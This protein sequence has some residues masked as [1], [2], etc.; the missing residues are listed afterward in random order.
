[1]GRKM[2]HRP[3]CTY[4]GPKPAFQE[5]GQESVHQLHIYGVEEPTFVFR[6]MPEVSLSSHVVTT[7]A[8][9]TGTLHC[10]PIPVLDSFP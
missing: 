4:L 1:M 6:S 5:E 2:A 8:S 7:V 9:R 10:P 3:A